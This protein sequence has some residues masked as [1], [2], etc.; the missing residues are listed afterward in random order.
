MPMKKVN[1]RSLTFWGIA[2][3]LGYTALAL[4]L[5][6]N[7]LYVG[8]DGAS[9]IALFHQLLDYASSPIDLSVI[10]PVQ[11]MGGPGFI[12]RLFLFGSLTAGPTRASFRTF[13]R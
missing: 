7:R 13:S 6:P 1:Q 4:A 10:S 3:L 2:A 5:F 11:G 9:S 12:R 8:Y